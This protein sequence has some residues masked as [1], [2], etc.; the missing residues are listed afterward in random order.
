MFITGI[1]CM[2]GGFEKPMTASQ[3]LAPGSYVKKSIEAVGEPAL[4]EALRSL[5][6]ETRID[7]YRVLDDG[8]MRIDS[9]ITKPMTYESVVVNKDRVSRNSLGDERPVIRSE[10]ER[11]R[12]LGR[13]YGG[14]FT[15][16]NFSSDLTALGE[17]GFASESMHLLGFENEVIRG[18]FY[19]GSKDFLIKRLVFTSRLPGEEGLEWSYE[20][21]G[22]TLTQGL[23]LPGTLFFSQIG[24]GGTGAPGPQPIHSLTVNPE[25]TA[26]DFLAPLVSIP[27]SQIEG[28]RLSGQILS[29]HFADTHWVGLMSNW[30]EN[31]ITRMG[32]RNGD[33]L[34]VNCAGVQFTATFF[35]LESQVDK[36]SVY[37]PGNA[38]V[39]CNPTRFPMFVIQF[40][41]L[42]PLARFE[43]LKAVA[44]L[45]APITA[46][47]IKAEAP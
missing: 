44:V 34:L 35:F 22:H 9:A 15:L 12:I 1:F 10:A 25:L 23:R 17:K 31:E 20:F 43:E 14:L 33:L 7:S 37:D 36:P 47:R 45:S 3:T 2:V 29:S 26:N 30:G 38:L 6:F 16:R 27:A 13:F 42:D 28:D 32:W 40:N 5:R 11:L 19:L 21:S 46:Q 39:Y 8:T 41:K 18:T 24:A 4:I